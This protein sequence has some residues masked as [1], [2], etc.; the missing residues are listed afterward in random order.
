MGVV[1]VDMFAL[2]PL[3]HRPHSSVAPL[4]P[5][6]IPVQVAL[7]LFTK[8]GLP[9]RSP[10]P[11]PPHPARLTSMRPSSQVALRPFTEEGFQS[12]GN[13]GITFVAPE[14]WCTS[15]AAVAGVAV[16]GPSIPG[17]GGMV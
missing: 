14:E 3:C 2:P 1:A 15:A 6:R 11:P 17:G 7:H 10:P 5:N 12:A 4:H 8:G 16:T 9:V 13:P